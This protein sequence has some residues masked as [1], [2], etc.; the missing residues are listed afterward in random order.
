MSTTACLSGTAGTFIDS[1]AISL[2][3]SSSGQPGCYPGGRLHHYP[4]GT[5]G[6]AGDDRGAR[7]G[8]GHFGDCS[9]HAVTDAQS[10]FVSEVSAGSILPGDASYPPDG[11]DKFP[12]T[13]MLNHAAACTASALSS[14]CAAVFAITYRHS[15]P[16]ESCCSQTR[17]FRCRARFGRSLA[18]SQSQYPLR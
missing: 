1:R 5:A 11:D 2:P 10:V 7:N 3:G 17:R 6:N 8:T 12:L 13:A 14:F 16:A 9:L 18:Y 15:R 4:I